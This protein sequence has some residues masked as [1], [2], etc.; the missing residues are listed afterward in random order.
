MRRKDREMSEDFAINILKNCEYAFISMNDIEGNPYCIPVSPVLENKTL[1]F[2][3]AK[4]GTKTDILKSNNNVCISCVGKT[5]I[6]PE[7]FTTEYESAIAFGK[8]YEITDDEY[9]I[10]ALKLIC[11]KF[12]KSNMENFNSAIEKSLAITA[13]WKIE[14]ESITGKRKKYDLE[15]KE[16]KFGRTN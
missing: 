6:V 12:A 5:N 14:I 13:I 9:K 15:G 1:Y 3:S 4:S 7:K 11:E 16:M 2:H 10:H 8:A